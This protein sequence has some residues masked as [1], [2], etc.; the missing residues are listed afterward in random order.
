M[1]NLSGHAFSQFRPSRIVTFVLFLFFLLFD[2]PQVRKHLPGHVAGPTAGGGSQNRRGDRGKHYT[3]LSTDDFMFP[4][5]TLDVNSDTCVTSSCLLQRL[6]CAN[7]RLLLE[8]MWKGRIADLEVPIFIPAIATCLSV[9]AALLVWL[10][11]NE[12]VK[13]L[14][15]NPYITSV[16]T[17]FSKCL[18]MDPS[19]FKL[20]NSG[21]THILY[22]LLCLRTCVHLETGLTMLTNKP[23][24]C[25]ILGKPLPKLRAHN[26]SH[27]CFYSENDV[28]V[29]V[30]VRSCH[31]SLL[32]LVSLV[33]HH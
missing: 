10:L 13:K 27:F 31:L 18:L 19:L 21:I 30:R 23:R 26:L 5:V 20:L 32:C 16:T 4:S 6:R 17:V 8:S 28:I 3:A 14:V 1:L 24:T 29:S 7:V 12:L 9:Q 2:R 25:I 22:F 15:L 33:L 11:L